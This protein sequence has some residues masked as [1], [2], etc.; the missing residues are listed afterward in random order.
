VQSR[1]LF[2]ATLTRV[3]V[4]DVGMAVVLAVVFVIVLG[5]GDLRVFAAL[6]ILRQ[7]ALFGSLYN[8]TAPV[9]EWQKY[10]GFDERLLTAASNAID[11]IVVR[12]LRVAGIGWVLMPVAVVLLARLGVPDSLPIGAPE[13][14][15]GVALSL[16]TSVAVMPLLSLLLERV[17]L[18]VRLDLGIAR[19]E[20]RLAPPPHRL[21]L[22][23]HLV[24]TNLGLITAVLVGMT[25]IAALERAKR[26]RA[27]SL[28]E[29]RN[30]ASMVAAQL[31]EHVHD[32]VMSS[33]PGLHLL[34]Y[35]QLPT[36]LLELGAVLQ[37][38][39][40]IGVI[41]MRSEQ[42]IAAAPIG[43]GRWVVVQAEVEQN[44][45]WVSLLVLVYL[46]CT[47]AFSVAASRALLRVIALPLAQ[48]DE[49][50]RR[51]AEHGDIRSM[52][53]IVP[54]RNDELGALANNFNDM[55]DMLDELA[56]AAA[57][58]A[59][60]DLRV[61]I[62]GAGDLP[63]AL[64]G[65][66]ARLNEVVEQIRSTSLELASAASEIHAIISEQEQATEQQSHRVLVVSDTIATLAESA[67][68]ISGTSTEVL[69][70]AEQALST[71][72]AM[73][74]KINL[75]SA[76]A[77]SVRAL[78]ELIREVAD[79]S[80]LLALNGALEATR[81]GEAG[82]GFAL[83]ASEMRRLAERVTGTLGDVRERLADIE[84]AGASTVQATADSRRL[85][86][87]TATAARKIS[88][89]T[90]RQSEETEQ[91]SH[92]VFEVAEGMLATVEAAK[93]TLAAT[94]GLRKQAAELERLT[95]QFILREVSPAAAP[96]HWAGAGTTSPSRSHATPVDRGSLVRRS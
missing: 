60:G 11:S 17:L 33:E 79:R 12:V 55:L 22:A 69:D 4:L 30:R 32:D 66:L 93:Q 41:D 31:R 36:G 49:A 44:L 34:P 40:S 80:D 95:R 68:D 71:T 61:D 92:K 47:L 46:G 5:L 45:A 2:V 53:R 21:S 39:E 89:V 19:R 91:V 90:H 59:K 26:I 85:A 87:S 28:A 73:I 15:C 14:L 72:D 16:A 8:A 77:G 6:T 18:D 70:N 7:L 23:R 27:D 82:R 83:V 20:H 64:R 81:A 58:V 25:A 76:R 48:L 75:L 3:G 50:T 43:D 88:M 67:E 57:A 62:H 37:H 13:L 9:R 29:Q 35:E 54:M 56:A 96:D 86:D 38:G 84:A 10:A 24:L 1:D 74:E 42:A 65:M 52:G 51:V 63:D 94:D 78:L